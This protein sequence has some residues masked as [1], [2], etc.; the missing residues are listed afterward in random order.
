[1]RPVERRLFLAEAARAASRAA[2]A[3]VAALVPAPSD[4]CDVMISY[5]VAE[6]GEG[7][8]SS[9]FELQAA[10]CA[11]GVARAGAGGGGL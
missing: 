1:M 2:A 6:T 8:D 7:G 11:R 10:L 5:R 4:G 9:V 3:P